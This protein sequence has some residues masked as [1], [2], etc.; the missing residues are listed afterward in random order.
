MLT[1]SFLEPR[2]V[3]PLLNLFTLRR[4]RRRTS[5]V[6]TRRKSNDTPKRSEKRP[7]KEGRDIEDMEGPEK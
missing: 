5:N 4:S 2:L 6:D 7:W 1:V 3:G